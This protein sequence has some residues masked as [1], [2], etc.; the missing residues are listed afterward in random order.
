MPS[1][2]L[3]TI[4]WISLTVAFVSAGTILF[5]MFVNKH[6]QKMTVMEW[7]WPITAL[8]TGPLGLFFYFK[9]GR[10]SS[11]K[12]QIQNGNGGYG[13]TISVGIGVSHCGAG[14][15]LGDII[16]AS[17][18]FILGLEIAGLALWPEYI[19]NF[20]L[21]FLLGI[22]FQYF[23]IAPMRNLGLKDGLV[24]AL[25]ADTLSLIAF[26]IGVFGWM[27][28]MQLVFFPVQHIHP[29]TAAYWFLMQI[30]MILGFLTSYP[31]N[32]WLIKKGV[33]EAM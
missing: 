24:A 14:C 4:A 26:E 13:Q 18:V 21:A 25:K 9:Y 30:A 16:G 10:Q 31:V 3:T 11:Q 12:W 6:R 15:T 19:V 28:L 20:S 23:S 17:L 8:Y 32:V 1:D 2:L 27:A 29:N 22:L 5:D 33:K 7:V